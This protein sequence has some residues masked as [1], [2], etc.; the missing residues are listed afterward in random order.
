MSPK[1]KWINCDLEGVKNGGAVNDH[2][3][4]GL[5]EWV[6]SDLFI[7]HKATPCSAQG[8]GSDDNHSPSPKGNL[9]SDPTGGWKRDTWN[10][11]SRGS[12]SSI[13]WQYSFQVSGS[14]TAAGER[15]EHRWLNTAA[16]C[17]EYVGYRSEFYVR[18]A[19]DE[20]TAVISF[21]SSFR[22]FVNQYRN[23]RNW[24]IVW[25]FWPQAAGWR[26]L[27]ALGTIMYS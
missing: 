6:M 3:W 27:V 11:M 10:A 19:A 18:G 22:T 15:A 5:C 26:F 25:F 20:L 24:R 21:R 12:S 23:R 1:P 2:T 14:S 7:P 4:N 17:Q 13:K 8:V 16:W 9:V